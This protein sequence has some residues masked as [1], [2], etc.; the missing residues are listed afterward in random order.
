MEA[1]NLRYTEV[2]LDGDSK[3][4]SVLNEHKPYGSVMKI[5]KHECMSHVQKRLGKRVRAVK[6]ELASTN[7]GPKER[8]KVLTTRMKNGKSL[9]RDAKAEV[10]KERRGCGGGRHEKRQGEGWGERFSLGGG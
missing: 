7:K 10:R 8:I 3:T 4:I 5:T 9:L 1:R 6:K 2:I